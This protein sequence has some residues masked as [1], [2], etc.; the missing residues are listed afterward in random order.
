MEFS[1]NSLR[2]FEGDYRRSIVVINEFLSAATCLD[3][4]AKIRACLKCRRA[5]A[6]TIDPFAV[7]NSIL[8]DSVSGN[9]ISKSRPVS[10]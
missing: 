3:A 4:L 9:P 5:R 10:K 2:G 6:W 7:K 8:D 1:T